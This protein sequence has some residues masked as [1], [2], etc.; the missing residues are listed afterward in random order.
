M[1]K[2]FLFG[3]YRGQ[4]KT[5]QS[6]RFLWLFLTPSDLTVLENN[7]LFVNSNISTDFTA[8]FNYVQ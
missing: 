5:S 2:L 3:N 8:V 1:Y 4:G 7:E 6:V